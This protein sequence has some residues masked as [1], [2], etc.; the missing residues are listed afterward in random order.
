MDPLTAIGLA[1]SILTFIDFSAKVITGAV[2]IYGSP[3]GLAVEG[4]STETVVAEMRQFAAKLQP[5]DASSLSGDEKSLCRLALECDSICDGIIELLE[6]TKPKQPKSKTSALKAGLKTKWHEGDRRKLEERLAHCRAQLSLQLNYLT[7]VDIKEQLD[8]L[9]TSAKDDGSKLEKLSHQISHLSRDVTV[10]SLSPT[11]QQQISA[12]LGVSRHAAD[13]I[14]QHRILTDLGFEGMYG[15]YDAVDDAHYKTFR[16]IYKGARPLRRSSNDAYQSDNSSSDGYDSD[17]HGSDDF[18]LDRG[19]LGQ[20]SA[21][22]DARD[23]LLGWLANGDGIFH[24][25]GKLGSGKSTLMKFLCEHD[26][27]SSF[28]QVWAGDRTLVLV[29]FFFWKP[30]SFLQRS[31]IGLTRSLLHDVLQAAPHLIPRV[32]PTLWQRLKATPVEAMA[33]IQFTEREIRQAFARLISDPSLYHDTCY[34]FFIDGL[35]EFEGSLQDDPRVL[36]DQLNSWVAV[37]PG[38]VKLCVSSREYNVFM[39]AFSPSQRISLHHL[40]KSDMQRYASDKLGHME[41]GQAKERIIDTIVKNA[42]GIFLWVVLVTRNLR[43]QIEN[44]FSTD[45]LLREIETLPQEIEELFA[46][47]LESLSKSNLRRAYQIFSMLEKFKDVFETRRTVLT[48]LLLSFMEDY[49]RDPLFALRD[50]FFRIEPSSEEIQE[51]VTLTIKRIHGYCRGLVEI[52]G[53]GDKTSKV[54]FA[55]RSIPDFLSTGP[56]A[57][58]MEMVLAGFSAVDAVSQL[59]LAELLADPE[60]IHIHYYEGGDLNADHLYHILF[61]RQC[62]RLDVAP[63]SY[64]EAL[65]RAVLRSR[66]KATLLSKYRRKSSRRSPAPRFVG[67]IDVEICGVKIMGFPDTNQAQARVDRIAAGTIPHLIYEAAFWGSLAW[68]RWRLERFPDEHSDITSLRILLGCI[69]QGYR[70]STTLEEAMATV[71][72]IIKQGLAPQTVTDAVL[73]EVREFHY[74]DASHSPRDSLHST[75]SS[76]SSLSDS[77]GKWRRGQDPERR[78]LQAPRSRSPSLP[79]T[80]PS[81]GSPLSP[82][83]PLSDEGLAHVVPTQ[84]HLDSPGGKLPPIGFEYPSGNRPAYEGITMTVWQESLL[85]CYR[86]TIF[87]LSVLLPRLGYVLERFL[88][89]GADPYFQFTASATEPAVAV[90]ARQGG[91]IRGAFEEEGSTTDAESR[92]DSGWAGEPLVRSFVFLLVLG[93]ERKELKLQFATSHIW[94]P[95]ELEAKSLVEYLSTYREH[96]RNWDRIVELIERNRRMFDEASDARPGAVVGGLN[97][98]S[99]AAPKAPIVSGETAQS[100]NEAKPLV[101]SATKSMHLLW[102]FVLGILLAAGTQLMR[103][104]PGLQISGS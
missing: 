63:Y 15:R 30:G 37:A 98:L 8:A 29:N 51:R 49:D 55:H 17:Q 68:V 93:K 33:K 78:E 75:V 59:R 100:G 71:E 53:D 92:H 102:I 61:L 89:H 96:F 42:H 83:N 56:Q 69:I 90:V 11:A 66:S 21:K 41:S 67:S 76:M 88:E 35:D 74:E 62:E 5:P 10:S 43:E 36:V 85:N 14:I 25:S 73:L 54:T 50:D 48:V 6:K 79:G 26:M 60:S 97:E 58:R 16:W 20:D 44:G 47:I 77:A 46:H 86:F 104:G 91:R 32:F 23:R 39:N 95:Y 94:R 12:L 103:Q 38:N 80:S 22:I 87:N 99:E 81:P 3:S 19:L 45:A 34:C 7:G 65:S 84:I 1:S 72:A 82:G 57:G 9:V 2:D 64:L 70:K 31:L 28:L 101:A 13:L 4:R 18:G 27:T 52:V 24:I 40:T